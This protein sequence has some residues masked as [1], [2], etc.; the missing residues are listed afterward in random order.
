MASGLRQ[1]CQTTHE[2]A[3][4]AKYVDMHCTISD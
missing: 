1:N 4:N 3:A 2:G